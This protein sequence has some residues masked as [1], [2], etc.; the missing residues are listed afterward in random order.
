M[1][2]NTTHPKFDFIFTLEFDFTAIVIFCI[3]DN[4]IVKDII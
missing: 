3:L 1:H 2:V 4:K